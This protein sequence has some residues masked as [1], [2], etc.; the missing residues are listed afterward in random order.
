MATS[1]TPTV[2]QHLRDA[3][4]GLAREAG[5]DLVVLFGSAATGARAVPEDLDIAVRAATGVVDLMALTN[6]LIERVG[7]QHIDLVDLRRADPVLLAAV[8][9]DG[10]PLFEQEPATFARFVSLAVRRFADTKK[11]R[12]AARE[13][14][15]LFVSEARRPA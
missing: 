4:A 8:A 6:R 7:T 1:V 11:F 14:I 15:R 5:L 3:A 13:D 9:R 10:V 2:P 12:D